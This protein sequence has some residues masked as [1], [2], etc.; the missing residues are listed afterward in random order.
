MAADLDPD[1]SW[2]VCG[3]FVQMHVGHRPPDE[4]Q[5]GM[6]AG[7][8]PIWIKAGRSDWVRCATVA[9]PFAV[10]RVMEERLSGGD[11]RT[12][13]VLATVFRAMADHIRTVEVEQMLKSEE[14]GT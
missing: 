14:T 13:E 9:S 7:M 3:L 12:Q 4:P 8:P 1:K 5:G 6:A 11:S 10:R 2:L